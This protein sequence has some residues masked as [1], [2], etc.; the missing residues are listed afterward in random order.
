MLIN[1]VLLFELFTGHGSL[2]TEPNS[3]DFLDTLVQLVLINRLLRVRTLIILVVDIRSH[4]AIFIKLLQ[5]LRRA[6][7]AMLM[8]R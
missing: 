4:I 2:R 5:I 3:E 8:F 7:T 6:V 1:L